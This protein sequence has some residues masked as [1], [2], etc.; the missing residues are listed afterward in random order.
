MKNLRFSLSSILLPILVIPIIMTYRI[1]AGETNYLQFGAIFLCFFANLLIDVL[2]LN[3]NLYVKLKYFFFFAV[4][5]LAV[6]GAFVSSIV[7]RH[8]VAPVFQIHDIILQLE[9]AIRFFLDGINPWQATY[10]NTHMAAWH[11]SDTLENP[12]LYHFVMMPMYLLFS[13]P[14]YWLSNHTIG[15]FDGRIPL[16]LLFFSLIPLIFALVKDREQRF[17][18]TLILLLNPAMFLYTLEGRSDYFMFAFL[19]ASL[20]LL[21]WRRY[22]WAGVAMALAF[23]VKQSVWPILPLYIIFI[24]INSNGLIQTTK[25][26]LS[27]VL[28]FTG[29][30]LPFFLWN[31]QA[32]LNSTVLYL[33]GNTVHSY[34]ISGYGLGM[35]LHQFGIIKDLSASYPFIVWQIIIIGPLLVS[36]YLLLR[37]NTSVRMFIFTYG[38]L[39]FA[40]WYLSR[41]FNNSHVAYLSMVFITAYFWPDDKAIKHK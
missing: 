15:Y 35:L 1:N 23:T 3:N 29:I 39:L 22:G 19:F 30:T 9:A 41:Y 25:R 14:F 31:P 28:V 27:F 36:L 8:Q 40:Y 37:K 26:L 6:G 5:V 34:P 20:C 32:F 18:F 21:Y 4:L 17:L 13:L 16:F 2:N 24:Y 12:A 11:F 10:H 38:I 7:V 33:S